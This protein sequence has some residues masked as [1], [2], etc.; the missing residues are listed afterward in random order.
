MSKKETKKTTLYNP[1]SKENLKKGKPKGELSKWKPLSD[2]MRDKLIQHTQ[3]TGKPLIECVVDEFL[4]HVRSGSK[5]HVDCFNVLFSWVA[6]KPKQEID[7]STNGQNISI[8]LN[9]PPP[10]LEE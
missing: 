9:V 4:T 2:M 1:K 10:N 3:D 7:L 5:E 8:T 6:N